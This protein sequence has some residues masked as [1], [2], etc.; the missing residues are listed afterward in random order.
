MLIVKAHAVLHKIERG[1][2]ALDEA[3]LITIR[4]KSP[5]L[6]SFIEICRSINDEELS[7][8]KRTQSIESIRKRRSHISL[9]SSTSHAE[10]LA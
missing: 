2:E 9:V 10:N 4:L 5:R 7:M 3:Y 1:K 6:C 8:K